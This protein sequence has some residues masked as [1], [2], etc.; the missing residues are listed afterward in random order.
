MRS[1]VSARYVDCSLL[2]CLLGQIPGAYS[3]KENIQVMIRVRPLLSRELGRG[4]ALEV[5]EVCVSLWSNINSHNHSSQGQVIRVCKGVSPV[6]LNFD[7]VFEETSSQDTV[8][9]HV[10]GVVV[11][12]RC[13][14]VV[15][16][17]GLS[18]SLCTLIA[19][20]DAVLSGINSTVFA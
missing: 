1:R 5:I 9:D 8:Y 2:C 3:N 20:V 4:T 10:K 17:S 16:H 11:V 19:S 7:R 12:H 13:V 15:S 14:L 6:E 18:A